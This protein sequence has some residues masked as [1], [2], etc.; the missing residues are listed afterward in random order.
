MLIQWWAKK[1]NKIWEEEEGEI[2]KATRLRTIEEEK[3]FVQEHFSGYIES[4][5]NEK[6]FEIIYGIDG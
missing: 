6:D 3:A 1:N 2:G 4:H 5:K